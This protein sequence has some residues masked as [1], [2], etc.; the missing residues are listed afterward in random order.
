MSNG[1]DRGW[2]STSCRINSVRQCF[3]IWSPLPLI[4]VDTSVVPK[5]VVLPPVTAS[6]SATRRLR[7]SSPS[8][9]PSEASDQTSASPLSQSQIQSGRIRSSSPAAASS[10]STS[11]ADAVS[12]VQASLRPSFLDRYMA[13]TLEIAGIHDGLIQVS[14]HFTSEHVGLKTAE[15]FRVPVNLEEE[16]GVVLFIHDDKFQGFRR[17]R[18]NDQESNGFIDDS[19]V[20]R[21]RG[22]TRILFFFQ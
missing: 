19:S 8:S 11:I 9:T 17:I 18:P 1:L 21:V 13:C 14:F 4:F 7:P 15:I 12:S 22:T 20:N 16:P 2:A 5:N 3:V 10:A 6:T